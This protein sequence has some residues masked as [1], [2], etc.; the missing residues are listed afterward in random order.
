MTEQRD[1]YDTP[2]YYDIIFDADT[3]KEGSFLEAVHAKHGPGGRSRQMLEPACGSGRLV[4]EMA[5]RG[6]KVSGFDGNARMLAFARERLKR[7]ELKA[8]L[9]EDWMQ[10]FE[11][12]KTQTFDLAHCLVSSFKYL[13]T[14]RDAVACI[15]RVADCLKPGGL[16][17]L[18]VHLTDYART[19]QEHEHWL[20]ERDGIRVLCNTHTWPANR[21]TRLEDLR[22]R[23]QIT[24][25]SRTHTQETKWQFRTY[26]AAQMRALLRKVPSL[27][28]VQ[29][30]DF[31]YDITDPRKLDDSYADIVLV[32]KKETD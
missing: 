25:A 31:T 11:L 20:A 14:E 23:L 29:C 18:G 28:L 9:W 32:L 4:L 7:A 17:V 19:G 24:H 10:S 8:R 13:Q 2:L 12:P 27:K 1:W 22:T 30:Y 15:Q 26:N 21:K 3:P 5:R 6:W 16:F